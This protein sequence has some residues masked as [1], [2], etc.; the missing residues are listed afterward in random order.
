[1]RR[2]NAG[3]IGGLLCTL[4][5]VAGLVIAG[6]LG[7]DG[8]SRA[9]AAAAGGTPAAELPTSGCIPV[10]AH[11]GSGGSAGC[12]LASDQYATPP[13]YDKLMARFGGLPVYTDASAGKQVGV[14]A[15][16]LGFVPQALVGQLPALAACH[17]QLSAHL[18]TP[19][20]SAITADC[21]S[22][23]NADGYPSSLLTGPTPSFDTTSSPGATA[24]N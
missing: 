22:L 13:A 20:Q 15:G 17:G 4:A 11:D 23:L 8:G 5:L 1:M 9:Q 12:V 10:A 19:S 16:T 21:T 6:L 18:A 2:S 14:I 3:L 7:G 24:A